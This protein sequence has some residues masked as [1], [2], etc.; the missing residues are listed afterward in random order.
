MS[1]Y[2]V[3]SVFHLIFI[4]GY[5]GSQRIS[6]LHTSSPLLN[7][8]YYE[9]LGISKNASQKEVKKAYYQM[10]KKYHP[11]VNKN[12][13]SAEKKFSEA[14]EAYEVSLLDKLG[15]YIYICLCQ[16]FFQNEHHIGI[17]E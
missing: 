16:L 1:V 13:P 17:I 3:M 4:S 2:S 11:D 10:A 8:N 12:D 14:T 5:S 7:K 6:S 15:I 9:V